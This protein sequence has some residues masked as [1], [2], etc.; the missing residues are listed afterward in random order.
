MTSSVWRYSRDVRIRARRRRASS[1]IPIR[2]LAG[3]SRMRQSSAKR[4]LYTTDRGNCRSSV[5]NAAVRPSS[6]TPRW[7]CVYAWV[8][9]HA[10]RTPAQDRPANC[11]VP[12]AT[13]RAVMSA[14]SSDRPR[15]RKSQASSWLI[16]ESATPRMSAARSRVHDRWRVV[17]SGAP[18]FRHRNHA[19]LSTSHRSVGRISR[20]RRAFSRAAY[21]DPAIELG[22]PASNTSRS[23]TSSNVTS[24]DGSMP[25][26]ILRTSSA[27]SDLVVSSSESR[28]TSTIRAVPS[29]RST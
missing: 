6:T 17:A 5:R 23:R 21:H 24:L 2:S 3:R 7:V 14:R 26:I 27:A 9:L 12:V 25:M 19:V 11:S 1:E 16:D 28:T 22:L 13:R 29:A 8:A 4:R 10:V 15:T 20:A 18:R